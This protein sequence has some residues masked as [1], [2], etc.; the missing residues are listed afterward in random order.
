VGFACERCEVALLSGESVIT[1]D[2]LHVKPAGAALDELDTEPIQAGERGV[3]CGDEWNTASAV[4]VRDE[5][6]VGDRDLHDPRDGS[7]IGRCSTY[8]PTYFDRISG[9]TLTS[10]HTSTSILP[11]GR[12]DRRY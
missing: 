12:A 4:H 9:A 11:S 10:R 8:V 7:P 5:P 3:G 1:R 6:A 2:V